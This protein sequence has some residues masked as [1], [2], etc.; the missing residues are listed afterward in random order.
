MNTVP[1]RSKFCMVAHCKRPS[2]T[3][4]RT[5]MAGGHDIPVCLYHACRRLWW[6]RG[7]IYDHTKEAK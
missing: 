4:W 1:L 3:T 6:H 2:E 5:E 7:V